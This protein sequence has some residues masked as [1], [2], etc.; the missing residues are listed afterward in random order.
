MHIPRSAVVGSAAIA[1]VL[2]GIL[3]G[4][5]I[6]A[7]KSATAPAPAPGG[8]KAAAGHGTREGADPRIIARGKATFDQY[9]ANCHGAEGKGD[10]IAGQNLPIKPQNL[11]EGRILNALPDHF[12]HTLIA[13]GGQAMK[14]MPSA[15]LATSCSAKSHSPFFARILPRL[16]SRDRRP[17][18]SRSIDSPRWPAMS[19]MK[20]SGMPSE[21]YDLAIEV[22]LKT[23]LAISTVNGGDITVE[24]SNAGGSVSAC[25][26]VASGSSRWAAR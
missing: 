24:S 5:P 13:H 19:S 22:P 23:N 26:S 20:S 9:C 2:I 17:Y 21:S 18:P 15:W 8:A 7:A 1:A 25:P 6:S 4:F 11:T 14:A 3:I 12:L 10:G 16:S